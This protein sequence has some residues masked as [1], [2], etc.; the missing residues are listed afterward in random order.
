MPKLSIITIN[1]N[2]LEGLQRTVESVVN[3][4]WQDFEYIV[5]DGDSTDGSKEIIEQYQ[6]KI[7][8]WV[9]EPDKGIYNAMNKGIRAA[10]GEYLQFLNSGDCL[11]DDNILK[12]VFKRTN[13]EDFLYGDCKVLEKD[14]QSEKYKIWK[15]PDFL[16]WSNAFDVMLNH[17]SMFIKK[18]LLIEDNYNETDYKI[19][20]DWVHWFKHIFINNETYY[21]L[22]CVVSLYDINGLSSQTDSENKMYED[23]LLFYTKNSDIIIPKLLEIN[24]KISI[25]NRQ[26]RSLEARING[27]FFLKH[28]FHIILKIDRIIIYLYKV[29]KLRKKD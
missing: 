16:N 23:K 28:S 2:N 26:N 14:N 12:K 3:Q 1:Y 25:E 7:D 13:T 22:N 20:S 21:Y 29:F 6:D 5:I 27:S 18:K 8:Y 4:T 10:K 15:N 9:S 24:R 11:I 19:I 17:Q